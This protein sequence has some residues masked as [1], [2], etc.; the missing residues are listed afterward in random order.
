MLHCLLKLCKSRGSNLCVHFKS[1]GETAQAIRDMQICEV[2]KS[3]KDIT[4]QKTRESFHGYDDG[5]GRCAQAKQRVW[6]ESVGPKSMPNSY[7]TYIKMQR[8]TL[9]VKI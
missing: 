1:T 5:A 2:P 7:C 8:L 9:N 4:L 6:A 3:L